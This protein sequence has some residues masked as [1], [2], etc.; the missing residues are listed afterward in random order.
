LFNEKLLVD[1]V[2]IISWCPTADLVLLVSPYNT[3]S[4]FRN[5][6]VVN[7]IWT[8]KNKADSEIKIVTWKPNG[9]QNESV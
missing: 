4:L 5:G 3:I 1:D 7:K 8:L 6:I 2:K 9:K